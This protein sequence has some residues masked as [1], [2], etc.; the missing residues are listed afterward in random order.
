M[1]I[2][3]KISPTTIKTG[4]VLDGVNSTKDE[5]TKFPT[6]SPKRPNNTPA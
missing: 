1:I 3:K 4:L 2:I 5:A 6:T